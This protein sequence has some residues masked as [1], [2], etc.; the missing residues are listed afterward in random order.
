MWQA[1]ARQTR[2]VRRIK[3]DVFFVAGFAAAGTLLLLFVLLPLLSTVLGTSPAALLQAMLDP[4]LQASLGLTFYAAAWATTLALLTGVPLAYLLARYSFPGKRWVEG[5]VNLPVVVPHTAAGIALL[6]I[7]GRQAP[8]GRALGAVGLHFTDD[9]PGIVVG[10]LFVSLPF[11]VNLSRE[12]FAL[13]D[14]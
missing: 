6:M 13:V 11:L 1:L 2:P 7:F 14:E 8:L 10:M 4:E 9:V 12:S 5:L 3:P